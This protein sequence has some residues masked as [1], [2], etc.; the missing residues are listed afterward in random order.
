MGG[1]R[2]GLSG[3]FAKP[4]TGK[5]EALLALPKAIISLHGKN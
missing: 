3:L 4:A 5:G 2:L 1:W